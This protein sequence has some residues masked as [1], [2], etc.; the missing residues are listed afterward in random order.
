MERSL[1]TSVVS[2]IMTAL[3]LPAQLTHAGGA[4]PSSPINDADFQRVCGDVLKKKSGASSKGIDQ[5]ATNQALA[6][7]D[8]SQKLEYCKAAEGERKGAMIN[9]VLSATWMGVAG[10]CATACAGMFTGFAEAICTGSNLAATGVDAVTT[11]NFTGALM[12]LT[13]QLMTGALGKGSFHLGTAAAAGTKSVE[14]V[15]VRVVDG[16]IDSD[17]FWATREQATGVRADKLKQQRRGACMS[18]ATAGLTAMTKLQTASKMSKS[19]QQNLRGASQLAAS[20]GA[21]VAMANPSIVGG[22]DSGDTDTPTTTRNTTSNGG[23]N[24]RS[25]CESLGSTKEAIE[26]ALATDPSLPGAVASADFAKNYEAGANAVSGGGSAG[27]A[28]GQTMGAALNTENAA[29]LDAAIQAAELALAEGAGATTYAGAGG[30]G[31][32]PEGDPM[33]TAM[34]NMLASLQQ[35]GQ[36]AGGNPGES[37]DSLDAVARAN[38]RRPASI[39]ADDPSLSLFGRV[40]YRYRLAIGNRL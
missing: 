12:S 18:A 3:V 8:K 35:G 22:Y 40:N 34:T 32:Q 15:S 5:T 16:K 27:A 17:A 4:A 28:L 10:V 19:A 39:I 26:C 7:G 20:D 2:L 13:P 31:G 14:N 25:E 37:H 24:Y 1:K 36:N 11:A 23:G 6:A 33:L 9:K 29:K 30:G 21:A 38:Q